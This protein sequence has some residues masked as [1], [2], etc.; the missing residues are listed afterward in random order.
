MR[1]S[2]R[3]CLSSGVSSA[4][5]FIGFDIEAFS[6]GSGN[7]ETMSLRSFLSSWTQ[8]STHVSHLVR[9]HSCF[10]VS[11]FAFAHPAHA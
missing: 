10:W 9:S 7:M 6:Q 8:V 11:I 2:T 5:D 4:E 3:S 1:S